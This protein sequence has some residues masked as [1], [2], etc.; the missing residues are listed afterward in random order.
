VNWKT[1]YEKPIEVR[2]GKDINIKG[3][4]EHTEIL[5][6]GNFMAFYHTKKGL[7]GKLKE[8]VTLTSKDGYYLIFNPN[9]ESYV[10]IVQIDSA[11]VM[12]P[13]FPNKNFSSKNNPLRPNIKYRFPENQ[14]D[15][16]SLALANKTCKEW[17]YIIA[18]KNRI[19]DLDEIYKKL[20]SADDLNKKDLAKKFKDIFNRQHPGNVKSLWFWH[21]P[22]H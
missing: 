5:T 3:V 1:P 21:K 20:K 15:V 11:G 4:Y 2:P 19:N 10:Y 12:E 8:G 14:L 13:V 16:L 9:Q 17:I 22:T 7:S 18:A 6:P